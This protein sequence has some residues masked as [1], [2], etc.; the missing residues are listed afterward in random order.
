MIVNLILNLIGLTEKAVNLLHH[1]LITLNAICKIVLL[2]ARKGNPDQLL[3]EMIAEL[4]AIKVALV[5][6]IEERP[7]QE[8]I[9]E[10]PLRDA[11]YAANRIGVSDKTVCRLT[12]RNMLPII[13]VINRK[14]Q[15]RNS[16]IER[17]RGYYRGE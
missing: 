4:I 11:Q 10:D 16:D 7:A 8:P 9:P 3:R 2:V 5:Q 13:C 1:L 6:G 12:Q 17:C 15:F 14:K